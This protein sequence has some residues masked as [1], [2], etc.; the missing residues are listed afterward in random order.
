[1]LS[2]H[3]LKGNIIHPEYRYKEQNMNATADTGFKDRRMVLSTLWIFA[4]LNYVY[5][6]VFNLYFRAGVQSETSTMPPGAVLG[7]SVLME[8]AIAMVL[9]SRLLKRGANRWANMIVGAIH[10]V[11]VFSSL[12][13]AAPAPFYVMFAVVEIVCTLGIIWYASRWPNT[14]G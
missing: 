10:T 7:F 14:E 6:D 5:A 3:W 8:G 9:L 2:V 12:F 1:M 13:T 4:T 11:A